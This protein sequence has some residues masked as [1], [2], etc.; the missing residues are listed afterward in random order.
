MSQRIST[1]SSAGSWLYDF[2]RL[3]QVPIERV[4]RARGIALVPRGVRRVGPC[5]VH[6]GDNP[7][8][9][10]VHTDRNSWH[11]F[12]HCGGG[13]VI[14]LV[15][16]LDG[17][18]LA[19]AARRLTAV[20][21][22]LPAPGPPPPRPSG[23]RPFTRSLT[24]DP[25]C[26]WLRRRGIVP[27]TA[28][29]FEAGQWHGPG[30]LA[31]CAAV[32]LHDPNGRPLGYAGRRLAPQGVA[33]HGK[34]KFPAGLPKRT[35][36]YN[37]HRVRPL[38]GRAIVLVEGPWDVLRLAQVGVPAVALLGVHLSDEQERL[39]AE[40][41]TVIVMLDGDPAGRMAAHE[42]ARRIEGAQNVELSDG[43]DPADLEDRELRRLLAPFF[44]L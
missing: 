13:D 30:F 27:D 21:P 15:A 42:A 32:R 35:L 39:L 12:T 40:A 23:F 1:P 20:A 8:A 41:D 6:G 5:P 36:L 37:L 43:C 22:D 16:R 14:D 31:G 24:L 29:R 7:S 10:V 26:P 17:I 34:W 3:R 25:N 33:H 38:A 44:S 9:F 2:Q 11:C 19:A 18:G 4:L 28:R